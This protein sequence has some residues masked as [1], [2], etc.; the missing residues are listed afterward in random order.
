MPSRNGRKGTCSPAPDDRTWQSLVRRADQPGYWFF[1][2]WGT[3]ASPLSPFLPHPA[4][5]LVF[6]ALH[7]LHAA[8]ARTPAS[9]C[10]DFLASHFSLPFVPVNGG[11]MARQGLFFSPASQR[12]ARVFAGP[13]IVCSGDS[14][15]R[16]Q[17][18][19]G[20]R[21]HGNAAPQGVAHARIPPAQ[22][23]CLLPVMRAPAL[24]QVLL[25]EGSAFASRSK[26]AIPVAAN[27]AKK[28]AS[29][30]TPHPFPTANG[31][32]GMR[33]F[34]ARLKPPPLFVSY[35]ACKPGFT[36]VADLAAAKA[37]NRI[38]PESWPPSSITSLP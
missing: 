19:D 27:I 8:L 25:R 31:G 34:P 12:S 20:L 6:L 32:E 22:G 30:K 23:P 13:V 37:P 3:A 24:A 11:L 21:H 14:L 28:T 9:V 2:R 16:V 4:I 35:T 33:L 18:R 26:S 7:C 36:A 15:V 17:A 5:G 10:A 29:A 38:S 1:N